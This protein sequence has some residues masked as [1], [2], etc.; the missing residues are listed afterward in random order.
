MAIRGKNAVTHGESSPHTPEY[1]AWLNAIKRCTL[2]SDR[3]YK[4]YG[5]RGITVCKEWRHC[6]QDFLADVGRKP[7]PTHT[8]DRIDNNGNYEPGNVRWATKSEQSLN[9]RT[10][11]RKTHCYRGHPYNSENTYVTKTGHWEC[12]ICHRICKAN[13]KARAI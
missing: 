10:R 13:R 6:Y 1:D 2:T 7:S 12:R 9:Q 4:W 11:T 3:S 5:A 8:L